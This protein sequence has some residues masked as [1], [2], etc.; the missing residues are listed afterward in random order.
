[1]SEKFDILGYSGSKKESEDNAE[2]DIKE[3]EEV[4]AREFF[5]ILGTE[6]NRL[7]E[8][9]TAEVSFSKINPKI[10]Y[11]IIKD[12]NG[13]YYK[14]SEFSK[15]NEEAELL[16]SLVGLD[17]VVRVPTPYYSIKTKTSSGED[18][19]ALVMERLDA[20]DLS[21]VMEGKGELPENFNIDMFF[22]NLKAFFTK[23]HNQDIYHRDAQDRN[24]M[25][26]E[27]GEPFVID[28]G[29]GKRNYLS[30][31]NPYK[32]RDDVRGNVTYFTD[33]FE[34]L[35]ITKEKLKKHIDNS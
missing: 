29:N 35:R 27:N 23:M 33:D 18:V 11:K 3:N 5:E 17:D 28:F 4:L 30:N 10:C 32:D 19:H 22:D 2:K 16:D 20:V 12:I 24:I 26:G 1:M 21:D 13:D 31:E 9:R 7:G 6:E 8:G 15:V 25:V 14:G 34:F